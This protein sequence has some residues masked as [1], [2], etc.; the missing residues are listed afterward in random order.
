M[1]SKTKKKPARRAPKRKPESATGK[2]VFDPVKGEIVKVS[3]DTPSIA[4]RS[5]SGELG[6]CGNPRE[7]CGGGSCPS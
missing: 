2:Y 6:P 5:S 3:D 1:A 7:D 4:S